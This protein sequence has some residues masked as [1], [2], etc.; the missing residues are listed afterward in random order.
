MQKDGFASRR[1]QVTFLKCG[2]VC[3]GTAIHHMASDGRA[4]ARAAGGGEKAATPRP[5]FLDRTARSPPTVRFDHVEYARPRG[6]PEP[7]PKAPFITAILNISKHQVE[8]LKRDAG[9]AEGNTWLYIAAD[10]R[11]RVRPPLPDGYLGK[12]L[13]RTTAV[14][15]ADD[16][17]SGPLRATARLTDEYVRFQ[18]D[19]MEQS[20]SYQPMGSAGLGRWATPD[21][22]VYVVSWLGL[23]FS[24]VDFGWG[25]PAFVG[26]A[27]LTA[28]GVVYLVPSPKGGD[29]G[30]DIVVGMEAGRLA[31]FKELFYEGLTQSRV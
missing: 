8:A 18:V 2:A 22:D 21:T 27:T 28:A 10:V 24:D 4:F 16:V 31:E 5:P 29:G 19:F 11:S 15:R 30:L 12:A 26:Q 14:A 6:G 3:L 7:K 20:R 23:P 25:R 1:P 13:V 17:V 9:N